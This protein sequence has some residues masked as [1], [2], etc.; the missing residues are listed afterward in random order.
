MS[1]SVIVSAV[2]LLLLSVSARCVDVPEIDFS[3]PMYAQLS[4]EQKDLLEEYRKNYIQLRDYYDNMEIHAKESVLSY[5]TQT[6]NTPIR[7]PDGADPIPMYTYDWEYRSNGG[8]Y[9]R[10]NRIFTR[11]DRPELSDTPIICIGII[12]PEKSSLLRKRDTENK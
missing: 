10:V 5:F 8:E 2:L 7:L 11:L 9:F 6:N 12:S 4:S 3:D 1:K